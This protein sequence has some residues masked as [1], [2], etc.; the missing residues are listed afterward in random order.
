[1]YRTTTTTK[2][3]EKLQGKKKAHVTYRQTYENYT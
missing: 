3:Y 2:E 1:M